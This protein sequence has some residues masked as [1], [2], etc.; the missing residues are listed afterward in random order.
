MKCVNSNT[1]MNDIKEIDA[2]TIKGF[3][4]SKIVEETKGDVLPLAKLIK[5]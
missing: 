2:W 4:S 5:S 1:T 3:Y